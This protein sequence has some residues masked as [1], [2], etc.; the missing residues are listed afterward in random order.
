MKNLLA[1]CF[2]AFA[3]SSHAQSIVGTWQMTDQ[4]TCFEANFKE[5][6]TEKELESAMGGTS[7]TAVAK[8]IKFGSKGTGEEGVFSQ[9]KKKGAGM[10]AFQ[11]RVSGQELQF[12]DKKSG[13]IT[14]R[15]IIEELTDTSLRFHDANKDCEVK[16]FTRV[17]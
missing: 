12:T 17:K 15:F 14:Q 11:Y 4:K 13:M 6:D 3:I 1:L 2:I 7:Q 5:S 10:T 9:G 8:L 16:S